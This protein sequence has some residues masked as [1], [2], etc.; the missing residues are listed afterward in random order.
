MRDVEYWGHISGLTCKPTR[1]LT[2]GARVLIQISAR[3]GKNTYNY[4]ESI[5]YHRTKF[6]NQG[7]EEP[8]ICAPLFET[9]LWAYQESTQAVVVR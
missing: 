6:G 2:H 5:R 8:G 1:Q 9:K 7:D 4:A 3:K